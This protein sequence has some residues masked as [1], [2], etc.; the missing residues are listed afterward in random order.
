MDIMLIR[1]KE[2]MGG[3]H[4]ERKLL[5]EYLE[6]APNNISEWT[7]GRNEGYKKYA[8]KIAEFYGVSLDWLSGNSDEKDIKKAPTVDD[9]ERN[10]VLGEIISIL[11][12]KTTEQQ[13]A[14]LQIL[15][16]L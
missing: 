6:V 9:G 3:R 15:R 8:A 13:K 4:G 10:E 16:H 7:N 11:A 1:I 2:L 14:I 5:A 12:T